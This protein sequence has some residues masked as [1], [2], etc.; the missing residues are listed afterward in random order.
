[1]TAASPTDLAGCDREP[2]HVPGSIQPHGVLLVLS[3]P[4]H[5]VV[6]ASA[7]TGEL[8]GVAEA[9][10]Q[11]LEAVVG[12]AVAAKL[13]TEM[14]RVPTK[15]RP[16]A[17]GTVSLAN[18]RTFSALAHRADGGIVLEF[19]SAG[20]GEPAVPDI[21]SAVDL[22]TL[23][24][25]AANTVAELSQLICE[26]M[27]AITGFDRVLAYR[28]DEGANGTVVGE[29]GSGRLPALLNHRFPASDIPAQ[30]R[31]LY[32]LNRVRIIPDANYKPVP[33]TPPLNP[34]T[35]RPLDMSYSALRSVSPVHVEYMRNMETLSSMSVSILRD[36]R[37]WG[38][39]SLHH[40]EP[41]TVPFPTRGTC[42][43]FARAYALRLSALEHTADY[44]RRVQVRSAFAKLL[45]VMA[46][47]GDFAAAMA[48]HAPD[49]LAFAAADGAAIV[50]EDGCVRLAHC[51]TED[52][53]RELARWLF[54]EVRQ[55]VYSTDSLPTVF[56]PARGYPD[57]ASGLLAIAVSK[58]HPSYVLWFRPEVIQTVRWAGD[59]HK[60]V[61]SVNGHPRLH[62]RRSFET[63]KETVRDKSLPWRPSEIEA[64]AELRNVVVGTVLRKA[65]EL[66]AL[67]AELTRSNKELESFSYS[68]SHDLRAPLRHVVGYAEIIRDNATG[69]LSPEDERCLNTIIESSEYAG[70][71]VDKLLSYSRLGRAEL[72]LV[73]V[74]MNLLI[75]E[76]QRDVM[77]D[78]GDRKIAWQVAD[79]PT[80]SADLMMLRMAVRDLLSNAVKYTRNRDPAVIEI[81]SREEPGRLVFFVKDNGVGFDMEYA[82]KLFGVFQRLHRWEDY[83]GTGIGLA[84]VRR[85]VER[86]GG[87]TWAKGQEN[88]GATFY[89]WLPK[90]NH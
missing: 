81:G 32:R 35:G 47:R 26:E 70:R 11:P 60:P 48:E 17:L 9:L 16:V 3:E 51:P 83:E 71:L 46:D 12:A 34:V 43:L 65:E 15:T 87:Q 82:D 72:Q 29:A 55:E 68:V 6:Q 8:V 80:V 44:E 4:D 77:R 30:A 1:M 88:H 33:V 89:F 23:R 39:I 19:E 14:G 21:H 73:P 41:R 38:L 52:H 28:F 7:N 49:V 27:R 42:D 13:R 10:G 53:V 58:L 62:P 75:R 54:A 85:V 59:P 2:I 56:P 5:A 37:L 18:G 66:A 50:T 25:E 64:A 78:A 84:N 22:F 67:N 24:A 69:K 20:T 36:G 76:L 57:A 31:E 40:R 86:H 63:W 90:P 79:L 74:D 61:E 45:A